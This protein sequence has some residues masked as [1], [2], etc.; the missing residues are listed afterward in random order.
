M[1]AKEEIPFPG[2]NVNFICFGLETACLFATLIIIAIFKLPDMEWAH[3]HI[4]MIFSLLLSS[5][6]PESRRFS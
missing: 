6:P 3:L 1:L 4:Y 5:Y 2:L